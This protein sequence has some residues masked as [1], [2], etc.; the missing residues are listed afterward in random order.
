MSYLRDVTSEKQSLVKMLERLDDYLRQR[1]SKFL[2]GDHL[3]RADCY[4]IPT[5]QHIRVAGK[6][7]LNDT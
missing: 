4:L 3:A 2:L 1:E 5:L 6:V 7:G